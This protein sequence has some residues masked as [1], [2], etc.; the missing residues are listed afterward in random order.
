MRIMNVNI[1]R[2]WPAA[3]PGIAADAI[4]HVMI[5]MTRFITMRGRERAEHPSNGSATSVQV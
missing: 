1:R 4:V 5:E 2:R 3:F